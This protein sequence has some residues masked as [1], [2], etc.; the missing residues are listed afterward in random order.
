MNECERERETR[1]ASA[2]VEV[3]GVND[4][5]ENFSARI[6]SILTI[7][8]RSLEATAGLGRLFHITSVGS[9]F[10]LILMGPRALK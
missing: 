2:G 9:F 4:H 10:D 7:A 3:D 1:R 8:S 6:S 5:I